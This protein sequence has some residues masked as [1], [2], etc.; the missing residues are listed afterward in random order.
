MTRYYAVTCSHGH[1]GAKRDAPITFAIVAPNAMDACDIARAM[2]GVKHDRFVLSCKE[3]PPRTYYEMR[4]Q[5]AY[6]RGLFKK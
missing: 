2:P 3:I 1:H 6:E 5:S 4:Q